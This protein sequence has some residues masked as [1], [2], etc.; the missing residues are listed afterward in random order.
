[1]TGMLTAWRRQSDPQR[2]DTYTRWTL[3]LLLAGAPLVALSVVTGVL[4]AG[5]A[6]YVA[7][8]LAQTVAAIG[9]VRTGLRHEV[10]GAPLSRGGSP[11]SRPPPSRPSPSPWSACR[12]R[13]NPS[14]RCARSRC[15]SR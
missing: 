13:S 3:Y 15:C 1:M 12:C 6:A 14:G 7:L 11:C 4:T 2:V 8:S 10:V 9:V 5:A